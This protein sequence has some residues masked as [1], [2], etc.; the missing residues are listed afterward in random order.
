MKG[1]FKSVI[2]KIGIIVILVEVITLSALG[3]YYNASFRDQVN[4]RVIPKIRIP[5]ELIARDLLNFDAI[6]DHDLMTYVVGEDFVDGMIIRSD[7]TV[8]HA[9]N[10]DYIGRELKD[11]SELNPK[12]FT[13]RIKDKMIEQ[14]SDHQHNYLVS[15]TPIW[16]GHGGDPAYFVY[17][18]S[19]TRQAEQEKRARMSLFLMG[20]MASIF[21]TSVALLFS[22][23]KLIVAR[24][25][26]T[27]NVIRQVGAGNLSAHITE[28]IAYDEIGQLQTGVNLMTSELREKIHSLSSEHKTMEEA[29]KKSERLVHSLL[30]SLPQN[31]YSKDLKGRFTFANRSYYK[32]HKKTRQEILGKTDFDLHPPDL[33]EKYQKDDRK[34][35]ETGEIFETIEVHQFK[36]EEKNYVQVLKTPLFDFR[37]KIIGMLGIFWDIT[38][39]M[40]VEDALR[41]SELLYRTIIDSLN[42]AIHVVDSELRITL[43]NSALKRWFAAG[44]SEEDIS[45]RRI[46]EVFPFL[47][48]KV[49]D[50]YHQ[51]F[52]TGAPLIAEETLLIEKQEFITETTKIPVIEDGQVSGIITVIRNI[53]ED[54]QA[55][56][57]ILENDARYRS[58]VEYAPLGII[59]TNSKGEIIETNAMLLAI[60]GSPSVEAVTQLNVLTNPAMLEAGITEDFR[61]CLTS[62]GSVIAEHPYT[63]IWGK[64]VYLRYYLTPIIDA[65]GIL[66]GVYAI[67]EDCTERKLVENALKESE[68]EYRSLF[69]NMLGGLAYHKVIVDEENQPV[70]FVFLEV[71]AAYERLT[72]L[73]KAVIGKRVTEVIPGL[74]DY[75]PD[76]VEIYGN[77]ALTG[78][79]TAL[80][81]FFEPFGVWYS[82]AAYSSEKGY[83]VA[84][85][86]DITERKW[87][88]EALRKLNEDLEQRVEA[89]TNELQEANNALQ[90]SLR[91]LKQT[92]KQ[93]VQAEKMAALGG[94]VA[95]VAHEIN[96]PVGV[97]V[98]AVSYLEQQT[99]D[100]YALYQANN[101]KR[102]DLEHYLKI[103]NE[104]TIIIL[105]NLHRAADL[106]QSFKQVAVDQ[107]SLDKRTF[108]LKEYIDKILLSLHPKLKRT[109]YAVSVNCPEGIELNSHPGDFSQI[110]TNFVINSLIHGFEDM[111]QGEIVIEVQPKQDGLVFQYRDNGKGIAEANVSKIFEPFHTTKRGQGGS[112]L[113]LHIVYN[114]VTQKLNGRIRCEST[115]GE[116]TTFIIEIPQEVRA[117]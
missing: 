6:A 107:T 109:Q 74:R 72:G 86:N 12:W 91:T 34:V 83:F 58:L 54:R 102:S 108:K 55:E 14:V 70:D 31:V 59:S 26:L 90:E 23:R 46:L 53:T 7:G 44:F 18:K 11:L 30:E 92:Q 94:L 110:I 29:L 100:L 64:H 42:E 84:L 56:R 80:E 85:Y 52:R 115:P 1:V 76:L 13:S 33:A 87:A 88:E 101:M 21:I 95:G 111:E 63:S 65:D 45:G 103:A 28:P 68:A 114:L 50:E 98:T 37:G 35:I 67:V 41:K 105:T 106:I 62:G 25:S 16:K 40:Y 17:I 60:F 36:G 77:V 49:V 112:G 15:I 2:F 66:T 99:R 43:Y 104:S 89:R 20:S 38:K 22:F 9:L 27:L 73:G 57:V 51:V 79:E 47:P 93:L 116:G 97:G 113:G 82:V 32:M 4:Q 5:G 3:L 75:E 8:I 48:E 81:F 117:N 19:K 24:I 10:R 78:K 96:T 71:N 39:K 69:K 61:Q